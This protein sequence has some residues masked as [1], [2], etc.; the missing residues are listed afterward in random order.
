LRNDLALLVHHPLDVA[1]V[2]AVVVG[3]RLGEAFSASWRVSPSAALT[4]CSPSSRLR[5]TV[6]R[7]ALRRT[8][9]MSRKQLGQLGER[10]ERDVEDGDLLLQLDRQ[11][12]HRGEDQ[13]RGVAALQGLP[14]LAEGADQTAVVEPGMEVLEDDQRRFLEAAEGLQAA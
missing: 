14:E 11:L 5:F 8:P 10:W 4:S 2:E 7:P 1:G 12:E 9:T 13:H 6:I 3:D